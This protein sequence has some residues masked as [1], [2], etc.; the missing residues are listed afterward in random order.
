MNI[1]SQS[2]WR[3]RDVETLSRAAQVLKLSREVTRNACDEKRRGLCVCGMTGVN[4]M[5]WKG[6]GRPEVNVG[7]ASR[8]S[9]SRAVD[10]SRSRSRE[11]AF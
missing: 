2:E 3:G 6:K 9:V 11:G 7:D 5:R 4:E 10:S 1:A 8:S